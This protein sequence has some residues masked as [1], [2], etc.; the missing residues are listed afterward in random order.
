MIYYNNVPESDDFGIVIFP[1]H[2]VISNEYEFSSFD[3]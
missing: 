3:L 1:E 2:F